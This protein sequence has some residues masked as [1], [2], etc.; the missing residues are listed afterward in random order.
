MHR[1][2]ATRAGAIFGFNDDLDARQMLGQR[3]AAGPALLGAGPFQRQVGLLLLGSRLGDRLF[4][5]L[6]RQ[7]ELVGIEPLRATA[8]LQALQL[9]DQVAQPVVLPRKPVALVGQPRP[10]GSRSA[11]AA[12]T[13]ARSAATSSGRVS[14]VVTAHYR[15]GATI[16]DA[17]PRGK[18]KGRSLSLPPLAGRS[19][20]HAPVANRAPRTTPPIAPPTAASPRR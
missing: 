8:E 17:Q 11:H 16:S 18:S 1:A 10:L 3:A 4:E 2:A 6:Q 5:I 15:T 14:C 7:I 20:A 12:S 9:P 19:A 13:S